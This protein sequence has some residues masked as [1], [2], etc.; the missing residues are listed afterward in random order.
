MSGSA[1]RRGGA[2]TTEGLTVLDAGFIRSWIRIAAEGVGAARDHLTQLDAAIGDADHGVNMDRGMQAA[3]AALEGQP[4]EEAPPGRLLELVGNAIV[5]KVGGAA[6]PLYGTA[7]RSGAEA[8]G[9]A[10]VFSGE[11]LLAALRAGLEGI[12]RLGAAV[13]GDKTI[14]DAW[15]PAVEAFER[16]LRSGGDA[17]AAAARAAVAAE[18]GARET[19]P[20]EA[21]KGRASYLGPRSIGHQDPGATSTAILFEALARA[22]RSTLA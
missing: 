14:V 16:E 21:R 3:L 12:Q 13:E 9:D 17:V 19:I 1:L 22:A 10:P 2:G 8:L 18:E 4:D 7:F 15:L 5:L 20:M 11:A 6:G